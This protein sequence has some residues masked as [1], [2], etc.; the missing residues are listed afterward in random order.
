MMTKAVKSPEQSKE[1]L[2]RRFTCMGRRGIVISEG[3][4]ISEIKWDDGE[5]PA[6]MFVPHDWLTPERVLPKTPRVLPKK[7]G[8]K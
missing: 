4:E 8:R 7:G 5:A 3:P 6:R 2:G 1:R